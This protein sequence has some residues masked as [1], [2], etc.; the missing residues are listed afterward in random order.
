MKGTLRSEWRDSQ[1]SQGSQGGSESQLAW[2]MGL[3][4]GWASG[5]C[6]RSRGIGLGS[7]ITFYPGSGKSGV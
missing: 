2:K 6:H 3:G 1:G 4:P 5:C 7:S